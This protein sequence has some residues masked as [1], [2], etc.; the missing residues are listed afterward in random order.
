[1]IPQSFIQ[2]LLARVDIVEVVGRHVQLKKSGQNFLGLCPFHAENT[3]SFTVS[4][5]KQFY[6]CFG[7]GLHGSAIGFVM[8]HRGL[9]YVEAIRELAQ[10]AGLQVPEESRGAALQGQT[11][12]L[13]DLLARAAEFYRTTLKDSPTAI[14]YLKSR[15]VTGKTAGRFGL[16]YAPD[17]WQPLRAAFDDYDDA[18][19][20]EAG[21]VIAEA[22]KRYDRFRGRVMFPI[23]NL[24]GQVIGFGARALAA[25]E[26]KYLN[27][28]E[29]PVFRKGQELYG[30][31]ESREAIRRAQR[32]LV[33]EGYLDVIQ[34][35]QAGFEE[36]VAALG[37]A[38]T[39]AHV[40]VLFKLTDH[41]VFAFDGDAAGRKA[42]RRALEAAL[43]VLADAKR[44]SF[45]LLPE[46]EDPDSLIRN[47]GRAAFEALLGEALP[48]SRFFVRAVGMGGVPD[49]A[50]D[51]AAM[52]AA[53]KPLLL[54][55]APG[56]LRMQLLRELAD[57][58][59]VSTDELQAL[60][61]LRRAP[62]GRPAPLARRTRHAEVGDLKRSILQQLLVQPL[63][64]FEFGAAIQAEHGDR[65]ERL[66]DEIVEVWRAA[67]SVTAT[68]TINHGTLLELLAESPNAGEYRALAA[69][70]MELDTDVETARQILEQAFGKLQLRR[71]AQLR[72]ARL[73]D[74]QQEPSADRLAAYREADRAYLS[75]RGQP[76]T[77]VR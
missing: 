50:E 29:T 53:A 16:G 11:R 5:S 1:M 71:L 38:I 39:P 14:D 4:P 35:A 69:Q 23:R 18:R 20:V 37:T 44:A 62:A 31:H 51:R 33:V 77:A 66:D 61:G 26:P 41:V 15:G 74:Y 3:P 65:G 63:L 13:T 40:S 60:Y 56:A 21:L 28:P 48:L 22:G 47:K 55:M 72:A 24:R 10:G 43:P 73:A 36:S 46:G 49:S 76:A 67:T 54:S 64:A 19:L 32:A 25:A 27:S 34:L 17:A 8:E 75:A 30:L 42:A 70:E 6:H 59:Q 57:A 52:V 58:A 12:A 68:A 7:C 45:L 2:D 9:N